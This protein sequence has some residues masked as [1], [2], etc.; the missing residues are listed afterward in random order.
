M[1]APANKAALSY[2]PLPARLAGRGFNVSVQFVGFPKGERC[3]RRQWR[4]KGAERV[5]AVDKIEDKRKPMILSGT[6]T[7]NMPLW[8]SG[9]SANLREVLGGSLH[10]FSPERKHGLPTAGIIN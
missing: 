7:G 1:F 4:I 2:I 6:A 8:S 5:A 10:T 3:D 9:E